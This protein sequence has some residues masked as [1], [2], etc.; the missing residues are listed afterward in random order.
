MVRAP[1]SA[2]A[3]RRLDGPVVAFP[4]EIVAADRG[5]K[6]FLYRHVY[7]SPSVMTVMGDAERIVSDLFAAYMGDPAAM[8]AGWSGG[9]DL[10]D[11]E[12]RAR[13]VADYIAGMTDRLALVEHR[14]LFDRT[15]DLR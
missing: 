10:G 2:D 3:V 13:R 5:I 8:P 12:R 6:A 7:R 1:A 14:R 4:D 9:A 15:P 11:Q